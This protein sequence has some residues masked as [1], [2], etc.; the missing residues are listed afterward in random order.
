MSSALAI[1]AVTAVLK[2]LLADRLSDV[3]QDGETPEVTV[4]P[5]D[6]VIPA[7]A[8]PGDIKNKLNLFL[9]Q[10]TPNPSWRNMAYPARDSQG[11]RTSNPPLAVNLHYLLSAYSREPLHAEI[12]LGFG[13]QLFHEAGVLSRNAVNAVLSTANPDP[14]QALLITSGL[15][16]QLEIIKLTPEAM[17]TEEISKLWAAFQSNYRPTV[18]YLASV[19]L[20][21]TDQPAKSALPVRQS[22]V[23]AMPFQ[24]PVIQAVQPASVG[25][26]ESLQLQGQSLSAQ[27]V[28]VR[29]GGSGWVTPDPGDVTDTQITVTPPLTLLAG[30]HTV[31]I[32]HLVDFAAEPPA[33]LR[34]GIESNAVAFWLTPT[35]TLPSGSIAAGNTLSLTVTLGVERNQRV[36]L[37]L[38]SDL[39]SYAIALPPRPLTA[40]AITNTLDIPLP[41]D[42]PSGSYRVRLQIDGATS[43]LAIDTDNQSPTFNQY[44]GPTLTVTSPPPSPSS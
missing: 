38:N 37:L 23:I 35:L 11:D 18:A 22:R 14:L 42:F 16:E 2:R 20:I 39:Q 31:Q 29:F 7:D 4:L 28:R 15:A 17:S 36:V 10:V 3:W 27:T 5:P 34:E 19:V 1:G 6:L 26:G 12:M 9:Y 41:I 33:D 25:M 43:P 21:E 40:P 8:S 30:I 24:R 13:M 32:V 44:V